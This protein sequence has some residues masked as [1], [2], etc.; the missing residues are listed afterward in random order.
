[1]T[2]RSFTAPIKYVALHDPA[3]DNEHPQATD[4]AVKYLETF[5]ASVLPLKDG[6]KL[7]VFELAHLTRAQAT[8]A[9][10]MPTELEKFTEALAY[11]L[12]SVTDFWRG[13]VRVE[14]ATVAGQRRVKGEILDTL[15]GDNPIEGAALFEELGIQILT[16]LR[17]RPTSK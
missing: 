14:H 6:A 12:V 1:V 2:T 8:R 4:L 16:G 15:F 11:S 7:A 10:G 9:M 13:P 3:L 5:D 17:L